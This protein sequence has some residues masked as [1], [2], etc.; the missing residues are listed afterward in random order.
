MFA[1]LEMPVGVKVDS[2]HIIACCLH[3]SDSQT[4]QRLEVAIIVRGTS[5]SNWQQS[6]AQGPVLVRVSRHA[7]QDSCF[8]ICV[9]NLVY[10]VFCRHA[11]PRMWMRLSKGSGRACSR[12]STWRS[13]RRG[14]QPRLAKLVGLRFCLISIQFAEI[15]T[16][17]PCAHWVRLHALW[18]S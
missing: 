2:G 8:I 13:E 5:S 10:D 9:A 11:K 3:H 6:I 16:L 12:R 1:L 7:V 4:V 15:C 14:R 18:T 17:S